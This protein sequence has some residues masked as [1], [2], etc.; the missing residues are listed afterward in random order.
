MYKGCLR[1]P[2]LEDL[3]VRG[4]LCLSRYVVIGVRGAAG[5]RERVASESEL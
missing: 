5:S 3:D 1:I 4:K 2:N